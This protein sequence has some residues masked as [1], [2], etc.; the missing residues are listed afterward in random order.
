[1]VELEQH[2]E[3]D[4]DSTVI[5]T[6]STTYHYIDHRAL[7]LVTELERVLLAKLGRTRGTAEAT[8]YRALLDWK[9]SRER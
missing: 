1:M 8:L 5:G 3:W 2:D 7:H 6:G 9:R 4:G